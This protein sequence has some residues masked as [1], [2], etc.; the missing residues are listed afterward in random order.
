MII[1]NAARG[2][3]SN[4]V[5]YGV[6]HQSGWRRHARIALGMLRDRGI[7]LT[8]AHARTVAMLRLH[9]RLFDSRIE[10]RL[11]K[12]LP[13][14]IELKGLSLRAT[15]DKEKR[16]AIHCSSVPAM[17]LHWA[18]QGLAIDHKKYHFVDVGSGWGYALLLAAQYPFRRVTGVE[19]AHEL[20]ENACANIDWAHGKNLFKAPLVE[21]RFESALEMEIPD[22]PVVLFLF[23]P[24]GEPV[25]KN[26]VERI[27]RSLRLAPRPIVLVY[28]NPAE[29]RC[30]LRPGIM[31]L[32]FT[33]IAASLLKWL[34]PYKVNAYCWGPLLKPKEDEDS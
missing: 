14:R 19:F 33:G 7:R 31:P 20:Y 8:I 5:R 22:G 23:N 26:F 30:L 34:S 13:G 25:M 32:A 4:A 28:V 12:S 1:E 18:L 11:P 10:A 2:R 21:T 29:H 24:F 27:E 3:I 16:A 9:R 17:T 15:T 6:E